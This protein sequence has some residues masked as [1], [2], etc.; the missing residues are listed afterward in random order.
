MRDQPEAKERYPVRVRISVSPEGF[1]RQI[2]VM[3]AWLDEICGSEGWAMAPAGFAGVVNDAVALHFGMLPLPR[4]SSPAS[5]AV[6][7]SRPLGSDRAQA[8]GPPQTP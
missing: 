1:G 3:H 4:L 7:A 6:I 8:L 5:A 2:E